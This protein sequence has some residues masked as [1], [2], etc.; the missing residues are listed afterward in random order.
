V[1]LQTTWKLPLYQNI[2][3][4]LT[5]PVYAGAYAFG[6]TETRTAVIDGRA[7]RSSGHHKPRSEWMVLIWDHHPGYIAWDEYERNQAMIAAN[8]YG[9][10]GPDPKSVRDRRALLWGLLRCRLRRRILSVA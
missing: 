7:R 3:S 10:S 6:K 5:N 9:H 4:I 8:P 2:R 1:N